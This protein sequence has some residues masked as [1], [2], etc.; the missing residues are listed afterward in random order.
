[1]T[2]VRQGRVILR[3]AMRCRTSCDAGN[4]TSSK[5]VIARE[6]G[7]MT[8]VMKSDLFLRRA[9]CWCTN[10]DVEQ[11]NTTSRKDVIARHTGS[12]ILV[13]QG[14]WLSGEPCAAAH[15]AM[16]SMTII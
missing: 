12:I 3:W 8:L 16:L 13:M 6:T 9:M 7:I 4:L 14:I 2:L 11:R 5:D 1:M 10:G 15:I